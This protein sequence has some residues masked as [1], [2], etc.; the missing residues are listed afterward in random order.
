MRM[1]GGRGSHTYL[2]ERE[3]SRDLFSLIVSLTSG[4]E[5]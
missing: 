1:M 4:D 3:Y 5:L 2:P